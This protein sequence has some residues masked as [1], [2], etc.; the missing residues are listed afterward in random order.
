MTL[1]GGTGKTPVW[2]N[3][4]IINEQQAFDLVSLPLVLSCEVQE[5]SYSVKLEVAGRVTP[6]F[7]KELFPAPLIETKL[8]SISSVV[9]WPLQEHDKDSFS[10]QQPWC[11]GPFQTTPVQIQPGR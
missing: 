2:G 5:E 11:W 9:A 4:T 6:L 7:A 1:L 3:P 8:K 10:S